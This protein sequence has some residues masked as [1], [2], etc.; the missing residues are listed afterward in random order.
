MTTVVT[1]LS[2]PPLL[3]QSSASPDRRFGFGIAVSKPE[4]KGI[5]QFDVPIDVT[6]HFRVQPEFRYKRTHDVFVESE[7]DPTSPGSNTSRSSMWLG[8]A[9]LFTTERDRFGFYV[10][11]TTGLARTT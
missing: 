6:G 9:L 11:G 8:T 5:P 10:G 4:D 3:A 2:A 1:A 7:S